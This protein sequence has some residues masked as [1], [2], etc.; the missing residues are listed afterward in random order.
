MQKPAKILLVLLAV[1]LLLTSATLIYANDYYHAVETDKYLS[2]DDNV[3][4]GEKAYG[5][6][7][8]G[9]GTENALIFYPGGKVDEKAYAPLLHSLAAKGVD[10]FLLKMPL[11]LAVLDGNKAKVIFDGYDYENYYLAGHS[12][13]GVMASFYSSK[14]IDDISGLFML[15]AY[16]ASD[17]KDA[18]FPVVFIYG[19]NDNVMNRE[20]FEKSMSLTPDNHETFV[21]EGGNHSQ[22]GSYGIQKGDGKAAITA[23]EQWKI[24][25]DEILKTI[26]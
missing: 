1:F 14:H 23:E 19:S 13:G 16:T 22:F 24:T 11:N 18:Q 4:V 5:Y 12:L 7:F 9:Q 20:K 15:G 17:L 21:I 8:D 10:C 6:F 2:S 3:K 26:G 25:T